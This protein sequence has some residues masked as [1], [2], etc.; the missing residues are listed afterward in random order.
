MRRH[1]PA[2][3]ALSVVLMVLPLVTC[4]LDNIDHRCPVDVGYAQDW[5]DRDLHLSHDQPDHC[6]VIV[7]SSPRPYLVY[8]SATAIQGPNTSEAAYQLHGYVKDRTGLTVS[9]QMDDYFSFNNLTSDWR[10]TSSGNYSAA[11]PEIV[12]ANGTDLATLDVYL[13]YSTLQAF[14]SL[15]YEF[16]A[17]SSATIVGEATVQD[18]ARCAYTADVPGAPGPIDW[19]W[20]V[21]DQATPGS[22]GVN[23]FT[24][25]WESGYGQ[26]KLEARGLD[27]WG[28][29]HSTIYW[30][31]VDVSGSDCM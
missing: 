30:V 24:P 26:Y 7:P 12:P 13:D 15:N 3:S 21:N 9:P 11:R 8:F 28:V 4:D 20:F 19:S 16:G 25:S 10:A 23:P 14:V 5:A 29:E 31:T 27:A 22:V 6:P 2:L 18:W 17:S 1:Q